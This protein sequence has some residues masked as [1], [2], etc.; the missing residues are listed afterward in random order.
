MM[1]DAEQFLCGLLGELVLH[2]MV[3]ITEP[4]LMPIARREIDAST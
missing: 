3:G 1:T 4:R 2:R